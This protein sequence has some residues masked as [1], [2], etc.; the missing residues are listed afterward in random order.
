VDAVF[1][2]LLLISFF[3]GILNLTLLLTARTHS[4][5]RG[6]RSLAAPMMV[7][8]A[9]TLLEILHYYLRYTLDGLPEHLFTLLYDWGLVAIAYSWLRIAFIHYAVNGVD[10]FSNWEISLYRVICAILLLLFPA[11]M[12][13]SSLPDYFV[14]LLRGVAIGLLYV[15]GIKGFL[16][17][18]I[19][20]KLLPSSTTALVI[21]GISMAV[22]HT[23]ALGE[24][25]SWRIPHLDPGLPLWVQVHPLYVFLVNLPLTVFLFR[26]VVAAS[27]PET[28]AN[29]LAGFDPPEQLTRREQEVLGLLC[30]GYSY[31]DIADHLCLSLATVKTHVHHIYQKFNIRRRSQLFTLLQ[32]GPGLKTRHS[33]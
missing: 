33:S 30:A 1:F 11:A 22:Y 13:V 23:V 15:A 10:Q 20:K 16:I 3:F 26:H 24:F 9:I 25:L 18:R 31:H 14:S 32:N 27:L 29:P 7:L 12:A 6:V 19:R 8:T 28:G 17:L 2:V 4:S 5:D 21:A